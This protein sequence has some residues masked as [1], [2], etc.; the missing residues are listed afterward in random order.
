MAEG[1]SPVKRQGSSPVKRE[2]RSPVKRDRITDVPRTYDGMVTNFIMTLTHRRPEKLK[3]IQAIMKPESSTLDMFSF[4]WGLREAHFKL[5]PD[6]FTSKK[7]DDSSFIYWRLGNTHLS[8]KDKDLALKYF[9]LAIQLAPHPPMVID[10][11]V[12]SS[13]VAKGKDDSQEKLEGNPG[14]HSSEGWGEYVSLAYAYEARSYL[15]FDMDEYSKCKRDIELVLELGC[16]PMIAAKLNHMK[17]LC[18]ERIESPRE[19][20]ASPTSS[21]SSHSR[22]SESGGSTDSSPQRKPVV[23]SP[24]SFKYK[25]S[26]P[27]V[28]G[29]RSSAIPAF[30][31]S[32]RVAFSKDMGRSL[33][34]KRNISHGELVAVEEGY[35]T[36]VRLEHLRTYCVVCLKR[37]LAPLPC[38]SCSMVVF[39]S[40]HCRIQGLANVHWQECPILPTMAELNMGIN[41][42]LALNLFMKNTLTKLREVAPQVIAETR[43]QPPELRGFS[44]EGVYDHTHYRTVY[45]LVTN[46]AKRGYKDLLSK[47]MEAFVIVKVLQAGGRYFRDSE[48]EKFYPSEEDLM[49]TGALLMH[50]M[51]NFGCNS[52]GIFEVEI[53]GK[54]VDKNPIRLYGAG[55]FPAVSLMNHSCYANC[56]VLSYGRYRV[57]KASRAIRAGS[58][59]T[60]QYVDVLKGNLM[61]RRARLL[62][63]YFFVCHCEACEGNWP[64]GLQYTTAFNLRCVRCHVLVNANTKKCSQCNLYYHKR[65]TVSGEPHLTTYEYNLVRKKVEQALKDYKRAEHRLIRR[66]EESEADMKI[67]SNLIELYDDFV[68]LPSYIHV[69]AQSTYNSMNYKLACSAYTVED[70]SPQCLVS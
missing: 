21:A 47:A 3:E 41:P 39:C 20:A 31:S 30:C 66:G 42:L 70:N 49:F 29:D 6:Y 43:H 16:P 37:T 27:P 62:P 2:R 28:L 54:E 65:T 11:K 15:L 23:E 56:V 7:S 10:D 18:E 1:R 68:E 19:E 9:N 35:C 67:V 50:H 55:I 58:Q 59:L 14:C 46:K 33:V 4:I 26:D 12:I 25:C 13:Q 64:E 52:G 8:R 24:V 57:V 53:I 44:Y 69:A 48:G 17:V 40:D 51:M 60:C 63:Q 61:E 36:A 45:N 5:S 34:A 32:V 38:P 22:R